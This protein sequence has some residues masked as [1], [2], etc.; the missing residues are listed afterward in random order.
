MPGL[1][2]GDDVADGRDA[3]HAGAEQLVDL[4]VAAFELQPGFRRAETGRHRPAAGRDEQV[5]G[6]DRLRGAA[7]SRLGGQRDAVGAR[8]G[9]GD[10]G[11]G[12]HLDLRLLET[13]SSSAETASSSSGTI[14]GSSSISVTWLPKRLKIDANSTP[15]APLP[16]IAIDFGTC[17]MWI[18]SSLVM[19][20]LR[21]ISMPGTLRAVDPVATTISLPSHDLRRRALGGHLDLAAA[22]QPA[23]AGD[24]VDLVL[25]EQDGR[26][27]R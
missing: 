10:L 14:R 20:R 13:R 2:E 12:Q 11:A 18:A 1:V 23:G 21:S 6:L 16:M 4:D 9:R 15:T 8:L 26:C 5:L 27:R 7:G 17:A 25:L 22:E 3:G 24:A 19:M